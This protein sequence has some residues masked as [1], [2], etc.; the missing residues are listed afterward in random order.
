MVVGGGAV[1]ASTVYH[2]ARL[3][4]ATRTLLLESNKLTSGT[5]WHSA[6]MINSLRGDVVDGLLA[7]HTKTLVTSVLEEETGVS[8]GF[9]RHGGLTV[10][11][12]PEM[13]TQFLR[14]RDVARYTDNTAIL[15]SPSECRAKFPS[16]DTTGL[17]GGVYCETDGSV[18]PTSLT[19]SYIRGAQA[20]GS[21]SWRTVESRTSWWRRAELPGSSLM[22]TRSSGLGR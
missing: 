15:L 17:L 14:E 6:A 20:G 10:T 13:M 3:G 22:M 4:A 12:N 8:P 2:L 9:K 19:R 21:P 7:R 11:S 1:G 5:T 16:L 18:D